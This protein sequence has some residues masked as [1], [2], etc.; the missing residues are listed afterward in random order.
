MPISQDTTKILLTQ[1]K[2]ESDLK[3]NLKVISIPED[4]SCKESLP[5]NKLKL[6]DIKRNLTNL[7]TKE[8]K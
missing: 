8:L 2:K 1:T 6:K 5:Q 7:I 3:P 4:P